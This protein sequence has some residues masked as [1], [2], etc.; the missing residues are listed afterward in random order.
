MIIRKNFGSIGQ[1]TETELVVIT[2]KKGT[3]T[4]ITNLGATIV[5]FIFKDKKGINRDVV[6]GY[7]DPTDYLTY[8][9]YFGCCVG[10]SANRT[11]NACAVI[12]GVAYALEKN[13]GEHNLHSGKN[14]VSFK[15]WDITEIN[16]AENRVTFEVLSADK[17][18]GFPGNMKIKVT[19]TL[20]EEDALSI[21]YEAVSDK[22]TVANFT[23]HSYFNLAGHDS[24]H[25]GTQK[26]K[27]YASHFTPVSDSFSIPTGEIAPVKGTPLDFTEWKEIGLEM[28]AD[29]EPMN[30]AGGY[31]Q[32][33]MVDGTGYR[34]MAEAISE[35]TGIHMTAY[36]DCPAVQ[37]YA[38]NFIGTQ[39]GK[40]GV[41]YESRHG[42]CLE[43]QHCPNAINCDSFESTLLPAGEKYS[44]KTTY[45]LS[46]I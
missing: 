32:N 21:E 40:G 12:H 17:E 39:T 27:L 4:S 23:N 24:G 35:E 1:G 18:Q 19:Y 10:R 45:Q 7:D 2:N 41:A 43:A 44:R 9:S 6:L 15:V 14:G 20:S 34:K 31:D 11:G 28:D 5:S 25:I 36:T 3:Q 46:L 13:A 22:D 38:G 33:F 16:E 30:F 37:L 29:F 42:F 26:L 8:D